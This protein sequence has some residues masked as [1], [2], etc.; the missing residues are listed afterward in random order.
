MLDI[1]FFY[2]Q[3]YM[4]RIKKYNVVYN[5]CMKLPERKNYG[6]NID[7]RETY[8]PKQ[9]ELDNKHIEKIKR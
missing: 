4:L 9:F 3:F 7:E 8:A 6:S 1:I 5:F 2:L